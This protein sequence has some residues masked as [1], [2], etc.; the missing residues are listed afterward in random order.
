MVYSTSSHFLSHCWIWFAN[1]VRYLSGK[2]WYHWSQHSYIKIGGGCGGG[3]ASSPLCRNSYL[4]YAGLSLSAWSTLYGCGPWRKR[5]SA[6]AFTIANFSYRQP[7]CFFDSDVLA[8]LPF[9]TF[10]LCTKRHFLVLLGW[11]MQVGE[12]CSWRD[13]E[14]STERVCVCVCV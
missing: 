2:S 3:V 9:P 7:S 14:F 12:R 11:R 6:F 5:G 13:Q 10:L 8:A 4:V 1:T